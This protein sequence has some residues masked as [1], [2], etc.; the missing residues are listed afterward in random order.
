MLIRFRSYMLTI[1][2]AVVLSAVGP[3]CADQPRGL[4]DLLPADAIVSYIADPG[5]YPQ[6]AEPGGSAGG[7]VNLLDKAGMLKGRGKII[8]NLATAAPVFATRRHA[9]S[10]LDFTAR[11][12]ERGKHVMGRFCLAVLIWSPEGDGDIRAAIGRIFAD[13][14]YLGDNG[15]GPSRMVWKKAGQYRYQEIHDQRLPD[16]LKEIEVGR[17]GPAYVVGL[18]RGTFARIAAVADKPADSL[19]RDDWFADR[20]GEL[21]GRR[22][23]TIHSDWGRLGERVDTFL[24][25]RVEA[26]ARCFKTPGLRRVA[27]VQSFAGRKCYSRLSYR[28]ADKPTGH[29]VLSDPDQ[30]DA[31]EVARI[32]P[33]GASWY[34]VGRIP[35]GAYFGRL[36]AALELCWSKRRVDQFD[37][38]WKQFAGHV[39]PGEAQAMFDNLGP[40]VWMHDWPRHPLDLPGA[41]T[42]VMEVKNRTAAWRHTDSIFKALAAWLAHK[43]A[44]S[45]LAT[46]ALRRQADEPAWFLQM[47]LLGPAL[48]FARQHAVLSW[49]PQAAR[50]NVEHVDR[51]K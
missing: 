9:V 35:A 26:V 1:A 44:G 28:Q 31:A 18:G 3:V 12:D 42:V 37:A 36:A 32:V 33:E 11:R 8:A 21:K 6:P 22:A 7:L 25:G 20:M 34:A 30:F 14:F 41:F 24:P 46:L 2:A 47:G 19:A 17:I 5:A 23:V 48:H 50:D 27:W 43:N 45:K 4:S 16:W 15:E 40:V 10:L 51:I 49:S 13:Y 39:K 38:G 29:V